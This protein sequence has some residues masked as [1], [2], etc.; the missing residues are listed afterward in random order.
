[1]QLDDENRRGYIACEDNATLVV[2]DLTTLTAKQSLAIGDAPDVLAYDR[3]RST[4]YIAAE[5]GTL[6]ILTVNT[7]GLNKRAQAFL[8]NNAH[9]VTVDQRTHRVYFPVLTD[10]GPKMLVMQA[11]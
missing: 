11:Q 1:L 6:S 10:N 9:I 4:L 3:G 5:S 8:A 2:F 7:D